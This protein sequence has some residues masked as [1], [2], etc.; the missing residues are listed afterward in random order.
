[1]YALY[2]PKGAGQQEVAARASLAVTML[3]LE[4]QGHPAQ[5][6]VFAMLAM[7]RLHMH[8]AQALPHKQ[9]VIFTF[10]HMPQ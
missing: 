3:I 6:I 1:M 2:A 8:S 5:P 9:T 4:G 10:L 7:V